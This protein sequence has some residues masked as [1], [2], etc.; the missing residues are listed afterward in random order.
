MHTEKSFLRLAQHIFATVKHFVN[1]HNKKRYSSKF[2]SGEN[3]FL[4]NL[5]KKLYAT[6]THT[7]THTQEQIDSYS[8]KIALIKYAVSIAVSI[9][10]RRQNFFFPYTD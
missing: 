7:H 10:L 2:L 9:L 1:H 4:L 5:H 3:H 6:Y 8:A